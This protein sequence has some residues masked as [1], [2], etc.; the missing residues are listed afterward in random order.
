MTNVDSA[1]VIIELLYMPNLCCWVP[2]SP[3]L[4]VLGIHPRELEEPSLDW[5]RGRFQE[6]TGLRVRLAS[7]NERMG[8]RGHQEAGKGPAID[9]FK[10]G[11]GAE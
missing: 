10:I 4:S 2:G 5:R 7:R 1:T 11:S 8:R 9:S 6:A 3:V